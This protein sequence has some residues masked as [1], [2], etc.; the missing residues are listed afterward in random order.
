MKTALRAVGAIVAISG[1]FLLI[2]VVLNWRHYLRPL[3]TLCGCDANEA[4]ENNGMLAFVLA[5]FMACSALIV[6]LFCY[7]GRS[8]RRLSVLGAWFFAVAS[9]PWAYV[10]LAKT[11][12]I[13]PTRQYD[14]TMVVWSLVFV[15]LCGVCI[16]LLHIGKPSPNKSL[17]RT[18]EG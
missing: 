17:E 11:S 8:D 2:V 9:L 1:I 6:G 13:E 4:I 10:A 18:R 15:L 12:W 7:F 14:Y 5:S 3:L 16:L